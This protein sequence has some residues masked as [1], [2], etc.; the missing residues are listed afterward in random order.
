M[1]KQD[2]IEFFDRMAP[3]WDDDLIRSDDIIS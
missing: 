3:G 1:R 2:V